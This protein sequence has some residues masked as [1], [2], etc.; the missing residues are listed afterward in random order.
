MSEAPER[1]ARMSRRIAITGWFGSDNMGD[2]LILRA[3]ARRLRERGVRP[4]AVSIDPAGTERSHRIDAVH[5]RSPLDTPRLVRTVR[6][7][8]GLVV[9]GGLIQSETSMW[10]IPF[11]AL[12]MRSARL[13][14]GCAVGLGVGRVT[15]PVAVSIAR[16]ALG[17]LAT[18]AVR[19]HESAERLL[20][21]GLDRIRVGADAVIGEPVDPVDAEDTVC[22]ILRPPNRRGI[23]TAAAKAS[24]PPPAS[25]NAALAEGISAVSAAT[26]LAIRMVAFQESRD[27]PVHR[28]VAEHLD[29]EVDLLAPG[30]D[31]VLT[32]VGRSR[33]VITMRYHGAIAALLHG[34]PAVLL[35]Y[36]PKM[37]S[38]AAEGGRWAPL[39]DPSQTQPDRMVRA[40]EAALAV[41]DRVTKARESLRRRLVENDRALDM[42]A[43]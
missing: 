7:M 28:G 13:M 6:S 29:T 36:S 40:V 5:H 22:V 37:G 35:D 15:N 43:G 17:R 8:D 24:R 9:T 30:L 41:E 26:G 19:D 31:D 1:D 2:E 34:R 21:W 39:V 25:R 14:P 11:H 18:V 3:L 32:E 4:V 20:G 10:N 33:L 23:G 12:R 27:M 42:V 38:L 16:R